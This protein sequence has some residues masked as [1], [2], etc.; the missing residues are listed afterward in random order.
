[1]RQK[2]EVKLPLSVLCLLKIN[3]SPL[4]HCSYNTMITPE[5]KIYSPQSEKSESAEDNVPKTL[6]P[7][8]LF[9]KKIL[10]GCS[11]VLL[12]FVIVVTVSLYGDL[13]KSHSLFAS[14]Q[15]CK[16]LFGTQQVSGVICQKVKNHYSIEKMPFFSACTFNSKTPDCQ[17]TATTL[18]PTNWSGM[19][20]SK[21]LKGT[22][23]SWDLKALYLL[24]NV[25]NKIG[26]K[27]LRNYI[28]PKY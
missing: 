26:L 16:N 1:M 14:L 3:Q 7:T 4:G 6:G 28:L 2:I 17:P 18:D 25:H 22:H 11:V 9:L 10:I 5:E 21:S 13:S 23:T 12:T 19:Y 27:N 8:C 20:Y 15:K 24:I